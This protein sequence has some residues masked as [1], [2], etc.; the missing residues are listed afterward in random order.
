[1]AR[2]A[3]YDRVGPFDERFGFYADVDMWMR[4]A[5]EF[6]VAYVDR[7]LLTLPSRDVVPRLF[8]L[9]RR[10]ETRTLRRMFWEARMRHYRDQ[11][12]RRT[13]EAG[14]HGMFTVSSTVVERAL[15]TR[16]MLRGGAA[17]PSAPSKVSSRTS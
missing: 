16:R 3:A 8:T 2:R 17:Q 4:L 6:S 12:L 9:A 10:D 5:E 1:M 14:R 13:L 11:P 15:A 7:P